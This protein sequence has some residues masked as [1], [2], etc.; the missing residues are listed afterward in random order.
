MELMVQGQG[1]ILAAVGIDSE[2]SKVTISGTQKFSYD[3]DLDIGGHLLVVDF[4]ARSQS[5]QRLI[6][7]SVTMEGIST[8]R[9]KWAGIYCPRYPASWIQ[10]HPDSPRC[11]SGWTD[12]G[13]PGIWKLRFSVP[14]F[15][16]IH[17][18]EHLGWLYL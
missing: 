10:Q 11:H 3:L 2:I 4:L 8:D 12:L 6:I 7:S 14:V 5:N 17:E 18:T 15:S 1:S 9:M 16:W 13:W